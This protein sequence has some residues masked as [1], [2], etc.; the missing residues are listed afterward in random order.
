MYAEF[1]SKFVSQPGILQSVHS[2]D[3]TALCS[4]PKDWI[5]A[6]QS[7]WTPQVQT[8]C[9]HGG[10]TSACCATDGTWAWLTSI[11]V[12]DQR[13]KAISTAQRHGSRSRYDCKF[14]CLEIL[15][16]CIPAWTRLECM[17]AVSCTITGRHQSLRQPHRV[18]PRKRAQGRCRLA[19]LSTICPSRPYRTIPT[20]CPCDLSDIT[21][22]KKQRGLI[23]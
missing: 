18:H 16:F 8:Q 19:D 15:Y 9:M 1:K 4:I 14:A 12:P 21:Y 5:L 2:R 23:I 3:S 11:P 22:T 13:H 7:D 20:Q 17:R 6:C 10:R